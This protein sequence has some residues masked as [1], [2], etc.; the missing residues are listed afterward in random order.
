VDISIIGA[1][2]M[3]RGIASRALAGAHSV[4]PLATESA[5]AQALLDEP[6]GD[7]RAGEAGD[8]LGGD[9]AVWSPANRINVDVLEPVTLEAGSAALEIAARAPGAKVLNAFLDMNYAGA[10]E[11]LA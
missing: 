11:V 7:A 4:A 1:A 3:A 2:D 10:V 6:G 9:I 5:K 8:P